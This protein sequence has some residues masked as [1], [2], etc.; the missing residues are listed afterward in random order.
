MVDSQVI[1]IPSLWK[2]SKVKCNDD[3]PCYVYIVYVLTRIYIRTYTNTKDVVRFQ[4]VTAMCMKANVSWGLMQR[5]TCKFTIV[6][7]ESVASIFRDILQKLAMC[8][9]RERGWYVVQRSRS[10]GSPAMD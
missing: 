8:E 10:A 9:T 2:K 3:S 5:N 1:V 4:D 7:E 6:S